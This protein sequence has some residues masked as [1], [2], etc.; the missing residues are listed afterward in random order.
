MEPPRP[1]PA[2]TQGHGRRSLRAVADALNLRGVPTARGG[3]WEAQTVIEGC[4]RM[5]TRSPT[6]GGGHG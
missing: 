5:M 6:E 4:R 2:S 1:V 3:R